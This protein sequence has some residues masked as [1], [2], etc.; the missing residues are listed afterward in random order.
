MVLVE[1]YLVTTQPSFF[2]SPPL[3][4][5]PFVILSSSSL[6]VSY[7]FFCLHPLTLNGKLIFFSLYCFFPICLSSLPFFVI[8]SPFSSL[9][10]ILPSLLGMASGQHRGVF[11][12]RFLPTASISPSLLAVLSFTCGWLDRH[13]P[14]LYR[15]LSE[16]RRP[17]ARD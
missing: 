11:S 7:V 4:L 6:S 3:Q 14:R 1:G 10:L 13:A 5:I 16:K 15:R 2:S 12:P 8:G 9:P 17:T